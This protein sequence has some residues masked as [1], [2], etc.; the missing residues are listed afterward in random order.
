MW[1]RERERAAGAGRPKGS[2]VA[3]GGPPGG[4]EGGP[5]GGV[6][7]IRDMPQSNPKEDDGAR[8]G[9]EVGPGWRQLSEVAREVGGKYPEMAKEA[10]RMRAAKVIDDVVWVSP[11]FIERVGEEKER[12]PAWG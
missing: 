3:E 12:G 10:G 8:T 7:V 11:E 5:P 4:V 2:G 9:G 1:D 6:E